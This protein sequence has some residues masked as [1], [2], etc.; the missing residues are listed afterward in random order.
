[1]GGGA[2]VLVTPGST[3]TWSLPAAEQPRL[4]QAVVDLV[5]GPGAVS[6]FTVPAGRIGSVRYGGGGAQGV[7]PAPGALLPAALRQAVGPSSQD[8]TAVTT[9]GTGR[10]DALLVTPV[11]SALVADGDGHTVALLAN[12]SDRAATRTLTLP[13]ARTDVRAYDRHGRLTAVSTTGGG[14]VRTTVPA[15][16]FAI[17]RQ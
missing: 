3:V 14:T 13:R 1:M 4:V 6:T 5:P 8:L 15:G 17:V 12:G 11:V 7:S 9:R 16:G 2:F 10:L